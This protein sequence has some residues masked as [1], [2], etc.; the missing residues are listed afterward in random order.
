MTVEV[1][2]AKNNFVREATCQ[3]RYG[4]LHEDIKDIKVNHLPHIESKIDGQTKLVIITLA[5]ILGGIVVA[6]FTYFIR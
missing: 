5:T 4:A 6:I 3:A 2:M 1:E